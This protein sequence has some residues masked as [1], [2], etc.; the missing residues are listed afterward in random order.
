[1]KK[2]WKCRCCRKESKEIIYFLCN[3]GR[4]CLYSKVNARGGAN[5]VCAECYDAKV[6][7]EVME[8]D[9]YSEKGFGEKEIFIHRKVMVS[10][11]RMS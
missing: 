6:P 1:M 9:I 5:I 2:G 8:N 11:D 3:S 4:K 7:E 10:L